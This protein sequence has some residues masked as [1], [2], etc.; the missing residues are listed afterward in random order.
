MGWTKTFYRFSSKC[1]GG[2][3]AMSCLSLPMGAV[4][5]T[6][7]AVSLTAV[8]SSRGVRHSSFIP[9]VTNTSKKSRIRW[10]CLRD[11][12]IG[13][14]VSRSYGILLVL[15]KGTLYT[16]VNYSHLSPPLVS[17]L[18]TDSTSTSATVVAVATAATVTSSSSFSSLPGSGSSSASA[19]VALAVMIA[20]VLVVVSTNDE[21]R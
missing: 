4:K 7:G 2:I 12:G 1:D 11:S 3:I 9:I 8:V 14:V 20:M 21:A 16:V 19:V 18:G 15:V 10:E 17:W 13:I 6:A 5:A